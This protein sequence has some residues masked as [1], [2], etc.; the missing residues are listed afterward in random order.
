M[1][2]CNGCFKD[3]SGWMKC[4]KNKKTP[5]DPFVSLMD[6]LAVLR[7]TLGGWMDVMAVLRITVDG[8][9]WLDEMSKK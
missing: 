1:D 4:Q 7:I 8:L 6:V 2:G 9:Q 3:Y 5:I